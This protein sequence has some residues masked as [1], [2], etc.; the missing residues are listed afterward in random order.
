MWRSGGGRRRSPSVARIGCATQRASQPI[1]QPAS[2]LHLVSLVLIAR[3]CA[4]RRCNF[5]SCRRARCL[6]R[7]QQSWNRRRVVRDAETRLGDI[8]RGRLGGDALHGRDRAAAGLLR[9]R[10]RPAR[11]RADAGRQIAGSAADRSRQRVG[12]ATRVGTGRPAKKASKLSRQARPMRS[13]V[14]IVAL[15]AWGI[16]KTLGS[17]R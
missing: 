2:P 12:Y 13:R 4:G 11:R 14:S 5:S 15:P 3:S 16:R 1:V 17:A 6:G 9:D 7:A 10:P 8:R